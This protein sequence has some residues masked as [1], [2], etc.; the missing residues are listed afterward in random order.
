VHNN[1][2][3]NTQIF[4]FNYVKNNIDKKD[5]QILDEI[6]NIINRLLKINNYYNQH[7]HQNHN[8]TIIYKVS[9]K[10]S[11]KVSRIVQNILQQYDITI[12]I[13]KKYCGL[14][15]YTLI[16]LDKFIANYIKINYI[17]TLN[18]QQKLISS[19]PIEIPI[20][21]NISLNENERLLYEKLEYNKKNNI[22]NYGYKSRYSKK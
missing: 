4:K 7:Q 14:K 6:E 1:T 9:N 18:N 2:Y 11:N 8:K 22:N 10:V 21:S 13:K 15:K 16:K 12:D 19:K 5:L 3:S 20:N 17:T